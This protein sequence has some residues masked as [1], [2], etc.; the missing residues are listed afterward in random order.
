MPS[1]VDIF[2][3]SN[4]K[5]IMYNN[6]VIGL[7]LPDT[8]QRLSYLESDGV[9]YINTGFVPDTTAFKHTIVFSVCSGQTGQKYICGTGVQE[10]RSGNLRVNSRSIDGLY[11]NKSSAKSILSST[12]AL[13]VDTKY[14]VVMDLHNNAANTVTLN[15]TSIVNSN[16]GTIDSSRPMYLFALNA[17]YVPTYVRIYSSLIK[18]ADIPIYYLIPAKRISD[19]VLGMYDLIQKRFLTNAANSGAFITE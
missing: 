17:S 1:I 2:V 4:G 16:T 3:D 10:G 19:Q 14:K 18:Q 13:T 15:G 12:Q 11:I 7:T 8:Y 5:P 6:K 9:A